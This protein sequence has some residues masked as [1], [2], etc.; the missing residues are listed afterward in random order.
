MEGFCSWHQHKVLTRQCPSMGNHEPDRLASWL[1]PQYTFPPFKPIG[2]RESF[3]HQNTNISYIVLMVWLEISWFACSRKYS[4]VCN[5]IV[6]LSFVSFASIFSQLSGNLSL[7]LC[8]VLGQF[9][10]NSFLCSTD[11]WDVRLIAQSLLTIVSVVDKVLF[12]TFSLGK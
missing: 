3:L 11:I 6:F 8:L 4:F 7:L 10:P 12:L 1:F 2:K 5:G 9:I